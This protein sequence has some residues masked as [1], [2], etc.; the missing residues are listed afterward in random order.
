MT[1]NWFPSLKESPTFLAVWAFGLPIL[2]GMA[3]LGA[4]IAFCSGLKARISGQ[5]PVFTQIE[6]KGAGPEYIK[7][8][9]ND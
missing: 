4:M 3:L 6:N 2:A 7:N 9:N 1:V 5:N 8:V